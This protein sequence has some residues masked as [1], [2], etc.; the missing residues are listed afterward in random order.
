[1]GLS[2]QKY[3]KDVRLIL[4]RKF[5]TGPLSKL[6][7]I[8]ITQKLLIVNCH[9]VIP[10]NKPQDLEIHTNTVICCLLKPKVVVWLSVVFL[11][12]IFHSCLKF[13]QN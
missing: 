5:H 6:I 1:M 2:P 11:F 7:T 10:L 9:G 8:E 4:K 3:G 13:T 12:N